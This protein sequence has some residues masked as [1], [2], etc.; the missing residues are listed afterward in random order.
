MHK[1]NAEFHY[2]ETRNEHTGQHSTSTNQ[3][4]N[5]F[6]ELND[7]D[8]NKYCWEITENFYGPYINKDNKL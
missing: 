6:W 5:Q 3:I 7:K 1:A 8:S 4:K 2:S